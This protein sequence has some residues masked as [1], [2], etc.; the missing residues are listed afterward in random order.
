M[1]QALP[2]CPVALVVEDDD[3]VRNLAAAVLEET[4]LEVIAC[5][6]AEDAI[7]VLES[8]NV[9]VALLFA[10]IRLP[11]PMDGLSLARTVEDRWPDVRVVVTSGEDARGDA[12][13][14]KE[15]VFM[16]KPWRALD[17]L[18]QAEHATLAARAA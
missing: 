2:D 1:G 5:A 9:N 16:R 15:A 11:G 8:R 18:V 13:L 7:S 12:R 4:D 14:P 3:A 10:D 6:S 17:V